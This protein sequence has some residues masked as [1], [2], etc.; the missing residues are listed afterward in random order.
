MTEQEQNLLNAAQE[1]VYD[2]NHYGEV[3]QVG[4]NGEYGTESSIGMLSAA[5]H[6]YEDGRKIK[7]LAQYLDEYIQHEI[8]TENILS[9]DDIEGS[10]SYGSW[11][12]LLEQALEAYELTENV[13]IHIIIKK[14]A[15]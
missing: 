6:Q 15:R 13:L 2:F 7:P 3:L 14:K 12:E 9:L 4:D 8:E 5:I 1:I 10:S 11:C